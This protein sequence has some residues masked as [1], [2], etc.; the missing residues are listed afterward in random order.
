MPRLDEF[1]KRW[2]AFAALAGSIACCLLSG[3]GGAEATPI[4]ADAN[5]A[6]LLT[7]QF[8]KASG[9][10]AVAVELPEPS[11]FATLKGRFVVVGGT[12]SPADPLTTTGND[13]AYC[14]VVPDD[15]VEVDADGNLRSVLIFLSMKIPNTYG[16]WIHTSYQATETAVLDG[17]NAFDQQKCRFK[18]RIFAMRATQ[19]VK[20]LNSDTVGHNT[21]ISGPLGVSSINPTLPGGSSADYSPGGASSAPFRIACSV[22]PWM[23]SNMISLDHPYFAVTGPT[24]EFE[25]ANV[26]AEVELT[27]TLWHEK[28]DVFKNVTLISDLQTDRRGRFKITLEKGEVRELPVELPAAKFN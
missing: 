14:G 16:A 12:V 13:K 7:T 5:Q 21:N 20:I 6:D 26:P 25:I 28:K 2:I 11:G 10:G 27:F 18:R 24:G 22:H 23:G 8:E 15:M 1:R 9:A 4:T 3:C 17:P 19:T